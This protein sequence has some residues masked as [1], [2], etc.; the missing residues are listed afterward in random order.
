MPDDYKIGLDPE[1]L[2]M[3]VQLS[4]LGVVTTDLGR[5][6][7]LPKGAWDASVTYDFLDMVRYNGTRYIAKKAGLKGTEPYDGNDWMRLSDTD[8]R[9]GLMWLYRAG[10][11]HSTDWI[12]T[13]NSK[14]TCTTAI[15]PVDGGPAVTDRTQLRPP[16][17]LPTGDE[18]ADD[19]VGDAVAS[20]ELCVTGSQTVTITT[21]DQPDIDITV[22][23]DGRVTEDG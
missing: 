7:P 5:I 6:V 11:I 13:E 1:D 15:I 10:P 2:P 14:Y 20:I 4:E 17:W 21:S 9:L 8:G 12:E 22:Y 3:S 18:E 19:A 23:W 16:M